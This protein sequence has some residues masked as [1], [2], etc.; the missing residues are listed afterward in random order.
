[1]RAAI[2]VRAA[3]VARARR[4]ARASVRRVRG[5]SSSRSKTSKKSCIQQRWTNAE[6]MKVDEKA[7]RRLA[8]RA[9]AVEI[10]ASELWK[11]SGHARN[12]RVRRLVENGEPNF[13]AEEIGLQDF[14]AQG[15]ASSTS[16]WP[17]IINCDTSTTSVCGASRSEE[18]SP[19]ASVERLAP[20]C[21]A[22]SIYI[23]M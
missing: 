12:A 17:R 2:R 7:A 1:M 13:H 11:K 6:R 9:P 8:L 10:A 21:A 15:A 3:V 22:A 5:G 4:S 18:S 14:V 16:S 20:R 23:F 19:R